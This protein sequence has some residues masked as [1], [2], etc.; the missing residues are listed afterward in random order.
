MTEQTTENSQ[1]LI[2]DFVE[3]AVASLENVPDQLEQHLQNP[4]D[5]SAINGVF[6]A[7]HSIKGAAGFLG[8]TVIKT[9]SHSLENT[10]DDVRQGKLELSADLLRVS[11]E[12]ID[13]LDE[14]LA[15]TM[16]GELDTELGHAESDLLERLQEAASRCQLERSNEEV[17]LEEILALADELSKTKEADTSAWVQRVYSLVEKHSVEEEIAETDDEVD[18]T[19]DKLYQR[20]FSLG[21]TDVTEKVQAILALF[22]AME[23]GEYKEEHATVFLSTCDELSK[24]ASESGNQSLG[25]AF[26]TACLD[27]STIL[28]SPLDLDVNLL[29]VIWTSISSELC[30][31]VSDTPS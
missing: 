31:M 28:D 3:E 5:D 6:R 9:F 25:K 24:Q 14:M 26:S 30:A 7:V 21:S 23:R 11:I 16:E 13:M 20:K 4:E 27:L 17:I 8:L 15:N 12:C 18:A 1:D 19:A 10:L 22:V 29:S 2:T